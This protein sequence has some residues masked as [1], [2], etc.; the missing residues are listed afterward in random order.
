MSAFHHDN[1][2]GE[3]SN[4]DNNGN[5]NKSEHLTTTFYVPDTVLSILHK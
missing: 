3:D 4:N 2:D 5:K 1:N